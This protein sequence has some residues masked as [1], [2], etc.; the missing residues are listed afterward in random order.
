MW[1]TLLMF[2]CATGGAEPP[3]SPPTTDAT[4]VAG[5]TRTVPVASLGQAFQAGA[6]PVLVDVRTPE[7]S[8]KGHVPGARNIPLA[9]L[10]GRL[11]E[12]ADHRDAEVWVI[13]AV[14]GRSAKASR[15]L[16]EAGFDAVNVDGGT[17]GWIA[18]GGATE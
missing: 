4:S 15:T 14:G 10:S 18:L 12:L 13:C 8:A 5:S 17:R 1:T 7:E 2:A 9:E 6:V 16:V 3:P 11:A